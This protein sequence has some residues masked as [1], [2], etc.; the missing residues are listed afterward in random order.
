LLL[1]VAYNVL[2]LIILI[3]VLLSWFPRSRFHPLAKLVN[4]LSDIILAPIR[5]LVPP[6]R[7]QSGAMLDFSALIAIVLLQIVYSML[8]KLV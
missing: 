6:M 1:W 4:Q 7:F 5:R 2:F 3:S 8:I